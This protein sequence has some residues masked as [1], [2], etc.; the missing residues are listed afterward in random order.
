ME[1]ITAYIANVSTAQ[2]QEMAGKLFTDNQE[3]ADIVF[4]AVMD[5]LEARMPEVEF[6]DFC[7]DIELYA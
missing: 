2:L 6:V 1:K 3:G 5:A 4:T 7:D